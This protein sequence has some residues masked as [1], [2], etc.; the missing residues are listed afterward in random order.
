MFNFKQ[1]L[2]L[3][4]AVNPQGVTRLG[5]SKARNW[6]Q[7]GILERDTYFNILDEICAARGK[8]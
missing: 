4:Q 3:S 2:S 1:H 7:E 5:K 8:H 6:R